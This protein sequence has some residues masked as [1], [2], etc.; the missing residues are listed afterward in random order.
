[1]SWQRHAACRGHPTSVFFPDGTHRDAAYAAAKQIC[2]ACVV[3][4]P[5]LE[6]SDEF[7]ATGD[8]NGVFGGLTPNERRELRHQRDYP[9][10]LVVTLRR[11]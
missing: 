9:H 4:E 8:R 11:R 5:C 10:G 6:L 3:R 1:M 2:A 7:V